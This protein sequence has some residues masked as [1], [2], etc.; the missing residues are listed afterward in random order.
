MSLYN[1]VNG[2]NYTDENDIT[3]NT[4]EDVVYM[5]MKNDVSFLINDTMNLYEQQSSFNPNMPLRF[6]IYGGHAV[7]K[8]RKKVWEPYL[9]FRLA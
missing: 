5:H 7:R 2:S 3:L 4:I 9:Q 1:A 6:F 8:I